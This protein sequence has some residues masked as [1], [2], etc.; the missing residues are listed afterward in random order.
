MAE[1]TKNEVNAEFQRLLEAARD[2]TADLGVDIN[3]ILLDGLSNPLDHTTADRLL[4]LVI[5]KL[6][7]HA[8]E[9]G[10]FKTDHSLA[11][12]AGGLLQMATAARERVRAKLT[13]EVARMVKS[14]TLH[15]LPEF[16]GIKAGPIVPIP[17][18]HEKEIAMEGGFI[19]TADIKLWGSN[20]RLEIHVAQFKAKHGRAPTPDELFHIMLGKMPL[21]GVGKDD[22]FEIAKLAKSIAANGVRKAPIID[23]DGALLDGNRRVAA[24]MFILSDSSGDF[25][26]EEKKR[27]E[28]VYVWQLT[29]YATDDDRQKVI[30]SLNF[31]SDHKKE[32]PKYIKARKVAEE[33]EATIAL[34]PRKPG[35]PRQKELK[36]SLA[37]KY[38]MDIE[39]VT[40][41]IKMVKWAADFEDH[42][43]NLRKQDPFKVQHAT[44]RYFEYFDELS[45]GESPGGVAWTLT[46]DDKFKQTVF[47]LLFSGKFE[48]WEQIRALKHIHQSDEARDVLAKAHHEPDPVAAQEHVENAV[49]IAR[50]KRADLR[51]LGANLRIET[52]TKWIQDIPPRTIRDEVKPDN[53]VRLLKALELV[54]PLVQEVLNPGGEA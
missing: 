30:V 10:D 52:F 21:E 22:E 49:T 24:C 13:S 50:T 27:A 51:S 34:E 5:D 53:L 3:K 36:R 46:A 38:A 33:W 54:R 29:P 4:T 48:S 35:P 17:V 16:N 20:E 2:M 39:D 42:H 44:K 37:R 25:T 11:S 6:R 15:L 26:P 18:F 7:A 1:T 43:I 31:E 45:K 9:R 41:F 8:R 23:V 19:K 12:P 32:W 14:K 40:R 47:D 28:H